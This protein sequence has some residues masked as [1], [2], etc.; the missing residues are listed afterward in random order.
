MRTKVAFA[1]AA[2]AALTVPLAATAGSS[3]DRVNGGGQVLFDDDGIGPG[4]TIAFTARD[5]ATGAVG[6]VQ[7][8]KREDGLGQAQQRFH[9]TVDCITVDGNMAKFAGTWDVQGGGTF[10]VLVAD[11]GAGGNDMVTVQPNETSPECD[12]DDD[13]DD[14]QTAL[15]RGNTTVYDAP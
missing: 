9:G 1:C 10:E 2:V 13:D 4:N 3:Y 7:Y 8:I 14:G 11:L 6:E 5:S 12:E 15:A